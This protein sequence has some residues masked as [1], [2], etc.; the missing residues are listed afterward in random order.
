MSLTIPLQAGSPTSRSL[1]GTW[2]LAARLTRGLSQVGLSDAMPLR[3]G[4]QDGTL[5]WCP[6][7]NEH[8]IF[9]SRKEMTDARSDLQSR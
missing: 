7:S 4:C 3:A 5:S 2:K 6:A 9:F 1:F 8:V